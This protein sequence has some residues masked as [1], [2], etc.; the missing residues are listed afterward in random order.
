MDDKQWMEFLE[1]ESYQNKLIFYKFTILWISFNAYINR[2]SGKGEEKVKAVLP[3]GLFFHQQ[4]IGKKSD[5]DGHCPDM[6]GKFQPAEEVFLMEEIEESCT[7]GK[8]DTY[9]KHFGAQN[10]HYI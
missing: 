8:Q 5:D 2:Y 6:G 3:A 4:R 1:N 7:D 10:T 9:L